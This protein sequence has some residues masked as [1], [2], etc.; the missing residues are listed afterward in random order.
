[1]KTIDQDIYGLNIETIDRLRTKFVIHK[2]R[3]LKSN[4]LYDEVVF[5]A[6]VLDFSTILK[7]VK[8]FVYNPVLVFNTYSEI[9]EKYKTVLKTSDLNKGIMQDENLDKPVNG[10]RKK[11]KSIIG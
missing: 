3:E 5:Y 11:I 6:N 2:T 4:F 9:N 8:S 10:I 1:M 7:L